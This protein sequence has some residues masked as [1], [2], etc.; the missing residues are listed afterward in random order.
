M[1]SGKCCCE[2]LVA[3]R[4]SVRDGCGGDDGAKRKRY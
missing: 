4:A 2:K 3:T 1:G